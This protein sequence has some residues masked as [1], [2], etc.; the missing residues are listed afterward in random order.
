M[1]STSI[2]HIEVIIVGTY[3]PGL[4]DGTSRPRETVLTM[5]S[6]PDKAAASSPG[7]K[8]MKGLVAAAAMLAAGDARDDG[9]RQ[10]VDVEPSAAKKP[11]SVASAASSAAGAP[12]SSPG[13]RKIKDV[14][15]ARARR[16]EQ[17]RRAAIESR[18]RKKVMI[19]ELQRSVTFYTKA[20]E[21]LRM[22]NHDLEQRLFLARRALGMIDP[23][24][25]APVALKS[26]TE[27]AKSPPEHNM[28]PLEAMHGG[29]E[30]RQQ[31]Q[32][33]LENVAPAIAAAT[34]AFPQLNPSVSPPSPSQSDPARAQAQLTA[35]QALYESMGYPA[36]AARVAANTLSQFVGANGT[37]P[38]SVGL[39]ATVGSSSL[40]ANETYHHDAQLHIAKPLLDQLPPDEEVSGDKYMESLKKVRERICT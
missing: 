4:F 9:K 17:N 24:A 38:S 31:Q 22:D 7:G 26:P 39:P 33:Q 13:R 12:S 34:V 20:N 2:Y 8:E 15:A 5:S 32:Q 29:D 28:R 6:N 3:K 18:R 30:P 10:A 1:L 35:T 37:T 16:L 11:P 36:V 14:S 21:N 27:E 19:G 23:G 40:V 25:S